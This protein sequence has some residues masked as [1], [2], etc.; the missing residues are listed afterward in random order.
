MS[1]EE[2]IEQLTYTLYQYLNLAYY[3]QY[4]VIISEYKIN[5]A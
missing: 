1:L 2:S 4:T 3:G 5:I